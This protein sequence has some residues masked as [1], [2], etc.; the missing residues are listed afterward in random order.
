MPTVRQ[1]EESDTLFI[2]GESR[3]TYNHTAGLLLL[4]TESRPDFDFDKAR[5][6]IIARID[7]IPQFRW[8]MHEIPLDLDLPYWVED[9]TFSYDHHIRRIGVPSPG[10]LQALSSVAGHLFSKHMDRSKPLWEAWFIDGLAD[11]RFAVMLKLH[12]CMMDGQGAVKLLEILCDQAPDAPPRE[13][14]ATIRDARPGQK[15][16]PLASGLRTYLR[17]ASFPARIGREIPALTVPRLMRQLRGERRAEPARPFT[18]HPILNSGIGPDRGFVFGSLPLAGILQ[19]KQHFEVSVNEVVLA[20]V[21]T[22]LRSY[23]STQE[24]LGEDSL[25]VSFPIS[26]R[27]EDDD[28]FSN[29]VTTAILPLATD[30]DD[31]VARLKGIHEESTRA[32]GRSRSGGA[33]VT[34]IL[35]MMPPF[36]VRALAMSVNP[37]QAAGILGANVV[38][39]NVRAGNDAVYLAGARVETLYPMSVIAP[40]IAL[41]I[42]CVSYRD[43]LDFG[44][45]LDPDAIPDAW[46]IMDEMARALDIYLDL[47][48]P[49]RKPKR[50]MKPKTKTKGRTRKSKA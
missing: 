2:A 21:G 17:L 4:N 20:L 32:K 11:N 34:D 26:L 1:L 3:A 30:I 14:P 7:Q 42:T 16:S 36:F 29:R 13:V 45:T 6:E 50:K 22:A 25:R 31:P 47:A 5:E 12:H 40:G 39:S 27:S 9:D 8:K 15:P 28:D 46:S 43:K 35:Q 48:R 24:A 41:N 33:G 44:L 10:D 19:V 37:E 18:P 38:V 23:L 49:K